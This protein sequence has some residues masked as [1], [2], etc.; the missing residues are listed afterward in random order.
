MRPTCRKEKSRCWDGTMSSTQ[1]AEIQSIVGKLDSLI[2]GRM[3]IRT[4]SEK[5]TAKKLRPRCLANFS[6]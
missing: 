1:V 3:N 6:L 4:C 5:G 2:A